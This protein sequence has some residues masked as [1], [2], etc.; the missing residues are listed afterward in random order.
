MIIIESTE[1]LKEVVGAEKLTE[2]ITAFTDAHGERKYS[3]TSYDDEV[4]AEFVES[5]FDDYKDAKEKGLEDTFKEYYESRLQEEQDSYLIETADSDAEYYI[6]HYLMNDIK[7]VLPEGYELSPDLQD[8]LQFDLMNS[9]EFYVAISSFAEETFPK[10]K[11]NILLATPEES[12]YDCASIY[13]MRC[14]AF[15][16]TIEGFRVC[17]FAE[18]DRDECR[19]TCNN[20]LTN[21]VYQQGHT[22]SEVFN[23]DKTKNK[24][25]NSVRQEIV[26][27]TH[28]I[29]TLTVLAEV[30]YDTLSL[31]ADGKDIV[32]DKGA[33]V[34]IF[35]EWHGSGSLFEI[36][37][38]DSFTISKENI[39]EVQFEK[40][41]RRHTYTVDSVYGLIGSCWKNCIS[42]LDNDKAYE[43]DEKRLD[44]DIIA[45]KNGTLPPDT[46]D[47][48][49]YNVMNEKEKEWKHSFSKPQAPMM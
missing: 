7:A 35:D 24:F 2:I 20:M 49:S 23:D 42:P 47:D 29:G 11:I 17:S 34:G 12:N 13:D 46:L 27:H 41:S 1:E 10:L 45:L 31:I 8:E 26:N 16:E 36:D 43:I 28:N 25:I 22:L 9:G 38:E 18:E 3:K 30:D 40:G 19:R 4:S 39:F 44:L 21:L 48:I 15:G 32:V 6:S 33:E 5:V 14:L 37:L